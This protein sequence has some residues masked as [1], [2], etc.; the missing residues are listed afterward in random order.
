MWLN[1]V[2]YEGT[3]ETAKVARETRD[4]LAKEMTLEQIAEP[5]KSALPYRKS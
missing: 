5:L 4:S 2:S 3:D 1:V